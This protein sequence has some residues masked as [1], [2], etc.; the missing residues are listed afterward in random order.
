M[1]KQMKEGVVVH[2]S[3]QSCFRAVDRVETR[4]VLSEMVLKVSSK[5]SPKFE[6]RIEDW[7]LI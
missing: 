6:T 2:S 3:Q 5:L 7:T 1:V 4:V